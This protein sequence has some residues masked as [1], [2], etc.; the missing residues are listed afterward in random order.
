MSAKSCSARLSSCSF[1]SSVNSGLFRRRGCSGIC[2][3][4]SAG[5]VG[6]IGICS[7]GREGRLCI[8]GRRDLPDTSYKDMLYIYIL[9]KI[10]FLRQNDLLEY[11]WRQCR[12]N[13][14]LRHISNRWKLKP[15]WPFFDLGE[16]F[17]K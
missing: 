8:N 7:L 4:S 9:S 2:I 1:C 11:C 12:A 17:H 13:H 6:K 16:N 15:K 14:V 5:E 10:R 3:L